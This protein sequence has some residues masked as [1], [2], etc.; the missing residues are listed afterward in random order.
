MGSNNDIGPQH[1]SLSLNSKTRRRI[2]VLIWGAQA[3]GPHCPRSGATPLWDE[4]QA[5]ISAES[6]SAEYI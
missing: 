1:P 4:K 6:R 5:G 2:F 3:G